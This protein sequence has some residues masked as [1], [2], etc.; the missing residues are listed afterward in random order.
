M[1]KSIGWKLLVPVVLLLAV[2]WYQFIYVATRDEIAA[3]NAE[4]ETTQTNL[5]IEQARADKRAAMLAELDTLKNQQA[6]TE[7]PEFDNIQNVMNTLNTVLAQA[8][9]YELNFAD[10]VQAEDSSLVRRTVTMNF[11]CPNMT[12]ADTI[13]R[14]LYKSPYRCVIDSIGL[15]A[16]D[17][18]GNADNIASL[19]SDPVQVSMTITY[20]EIAQQ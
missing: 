5:T 13:I 12:A 20:Y 15:A 19:A 3:A 4:L 7:I 6:V 16:D 18:A 1:N 8:T 10:P 2:I 11:V 9:S 14:D 17:A